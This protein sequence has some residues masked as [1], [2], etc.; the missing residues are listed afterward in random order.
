MIY[1]RKMSQQKITIDKISIVIIK[2]MNSYL[3][4]YFLGTNFSVPPI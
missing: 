3:T 2:S 1:S 4:N